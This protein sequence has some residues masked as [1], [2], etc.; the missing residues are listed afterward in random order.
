MISKKN[1]ILK[2]NQYFDKLWPLNRSLTGSGSRKTHK[3]L[4][5]IIPLKTHEIKS[6]KKVND[7]II[8]QEWNVKNAYIMNTRGEKIIDFM[9]NNLHLVGYSKSFSGYIS[10]K[11]LKKKLFY[12]KDAPNAIPY[13]TSYYKKDWGFCLSFNQYKK[14]ID[15]KYYVKID[16]TL[17]KGSMTW[18]EFYLPG[19]IKKEILIH[20]YTCHPSLAINELSGPIITALLANE[21]SKVKKRYYS[22]RFIFAPETI[23]SIA[24]LHMK[25]AKLKKNLLAGFV[26]NSVGYKKYI[27]YKKSKNSK[28]LGD[29]AAI[30][31]LKKLKNMK[32]K[33]LDFEPTGSD[34]R[35][36]CSIGYNLP[37]GVV[38]SKPYYNY[39]EYHTSL[40]NKKILNFEN[41]FNL[42]KIFLRIFQEIKNIE[43]KNFKNISINQKNR[44]SKKKN[45]IYPLNLI[46]LGEPY[47]SK[48]KIHYKTIKA[49]A[50]PDKLTLALKWLVHYSD[51]KNSLKDISVKSKINLNILTKAFKILK[52]AK[53]F[54]QII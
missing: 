34:E 1:F 11:K 5:E 23:G 39:P 53:I 35:Q 14:L 8:P 30:K 10:K 38:L 40:D 45:E 43:N 28:N 24:Y 46:T 41:L 54:K 26:C 20:T 7:W 48:Y 15:D 16:T 9:N 47:L 49:H 42:M 36:Y 50:G 2:F 27:T 17:K 4:S 13:R 52:K 18:S 12:L 44:V 31:I 29:I 6:G 33:I 22:F 3:I 51:G 37:V 21:I 32:T 19:I 25:G